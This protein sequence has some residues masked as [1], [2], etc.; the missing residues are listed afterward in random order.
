M[1]SDL[2]PIAAFD[3]PLTANIARGRLEAEDIGGVKLLVPAGDVER[4]RSVLADADAAVAERME[5]S[6]QFAADL[7]ERPTDEWEEEPSA[8][9]EP[10]DQPT[11]REEDAARAFKSAV[12]GILFCPLQLYTAWLL[13]QVAMNPE[14]LR[15]AYFWCAVG[16]WTIL[17]PYLIMI[18]AF[19]AFAQGD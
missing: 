1:K 18:V 15:R 2:V 19:V 5:T 16:A 17:L 12:L 3:S 8:I 11:S 6:S 10:Y 14:P 9:P 13:I 4:A 7:A